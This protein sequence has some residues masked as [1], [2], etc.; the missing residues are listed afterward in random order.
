MKESK[1]YN[2]RTELT[3]DELEAVSKVCLMPLKDLPLRGRP[4]EERRLAAF[5]RERHKQTNGDPEGFEI[6]TI[7][8]QMVASKTFRK[9]CHTVAY[10]K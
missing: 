7:A 10:G 2:E 9:A 1:D 6:P 8:I 5:C 4:E 3:E